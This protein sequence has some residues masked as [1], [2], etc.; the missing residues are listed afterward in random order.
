MVLR[1]KPFPDPDKKDLWNNNGFVSVSPDPE[2]VGD[3]DGKGVRASQYMWKTVTTGF[4]PLKFVSVGYNSGL[5]FP[6]FYILIGLPFVLQL[7][8]YGS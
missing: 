7:L 6:P 3:H 5:S 2:S 1:W 4:G 8:T